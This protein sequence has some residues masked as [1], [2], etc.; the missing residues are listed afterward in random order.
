MSRRAVL[1]AI[2][3]LAVA[4][5]L[6]ARLIAQGPAQSNRLIVLF[7]L[8]LLAAVAGWLTGLTWRARTAREAQGLVGAGACAL[9]A[10]A[11]LLTLFPRWLPSDNGILGT[12]LLGGLLMAAGT[13]LA[14]SGA[15]ALAGVR[16][17]G[18][19]LLA[20]LLAFVAATGGGMIAPLSAIQSPWL[21]VAAVGLGALLPN[22]TRL[23]ALARPLALGAAGGLL[24]LVVLLVR[25]PGD[26]ATA[27]RSLRL[28]S[29]PVVVLVWAA[30]LLIVDLTV[31]EGAVGKRER[32]PNSRHPA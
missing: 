10:G 28:Y 21:V 27:S 24:A 12:A 18:A 22:R 13:S 16:R 6:G 14:L 25:G 26:W 3:A 11:A 4:A 20:S 5:E 8:G 31:S 2:I 23:P 15:L 29:F 17:P 1:T 7:P 19:I 9:I 32:E 30:G